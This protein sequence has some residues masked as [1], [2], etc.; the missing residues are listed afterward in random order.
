MKNN[1]FKVFFFLFCILLSGCET[2]DSITEN[3]QIGHINN[4]DS[5]KP[6]KDWFNL[7][8]QNKKEN[9]ILDF[10]DKIKWNNAKHFEFEEYSITQIKIKFIKNYQIKLSD[11][12]LNKFAIIILRDKTTDNIF[13]YLVG[14]NKKLK[15]NGEDL[16]FDIFKNNDIFII[17]TNLNDLQKTEKKSKRQNNKSEQEVCYELVEVFSDGSVTPTGIQWCVVPAGYGHPST[18]DSGGSG[19]GGSS[20]SGDLSSE[21][22]QQLYDWLEHIYDGELENNECA[23]QVYSKLKNTGTMHNVLKDFMGEAPVAHIEWDIRALPEDVNGTTYATDNNEL[24][25]ISLDQHYVDNASSISL[26][27]TMLHEALH[28]EVMRKMISVYQYPEPDSAL[29]NHFPTYWNYYSAWYQLVDPE[30]Q[31]IPTF[32]HNHMADMYRGRIIEGLKEFDRA[33]GTSHDDW[34]YE[35]LAW[36]GLEGT[37]AWD[38]FEDDHPSLAA[39]YEDYYEKQANKGNSCSN[40]VHEKPEKL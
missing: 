19:T 40:Y 13:S 8:K 24:I 26:A 17:E 3:E 18:G 10:I 20:S 29:E 35:A 7:Q 1:Y 34:E 37:L 25:N 27:R 15:L 22:D 30:D 23:N 5:I 4:Q 2:E 39:E 32:M 21:F 28:A 14:S 36:A 9:D 33:N 6:I 11:K 16:F 38:N 12:V 31:N